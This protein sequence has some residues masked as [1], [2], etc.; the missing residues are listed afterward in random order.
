MTDNN[1]NIKFHPKKPSSQL[2]DFVHLYWEHVNVTNKPQTVSILPD[3]FYK[4]IIIKQK[5]N[6][7]AYFMTG[8]WKNKMEF[9]I[10]T[11]AHLYGIKFKILAPEYIFQNEIATILQ[12][13]KNLPLDFL[14]MQDLEFEN[15]DSF[16]EQIEHVLKEKL[17]KVKKIKANKLQLS[18]LLYRLDGNIT[19]EEV[20]KQI[21]WGNQQINRYL[22]KYLGVSLKTYLNIQKC[23]ASYFH[24]R[25]GEFYPTNEYYDQAHF[26]REI[27]K[28]T[29]K[30]PKELF[31][32]QNDQFIQLKFIQKK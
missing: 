15:I 7:T 31:K 26:I 17:S 8:I 21:N 13:H 30:T 20:S 6:I 4:I 22:N 9:T 2:D 23:Y 29:G 1:K 10:P 27:K 16:T 28:H 3:S 14:K 32:K 11:N 24:I 25:D 5:G 12:S 18:H 19:V